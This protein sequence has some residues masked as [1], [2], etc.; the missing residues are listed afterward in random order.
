MKW[1][2]QKRD[3]A[4]LEREVIKYLSSKG[5]GGGVTATEIAFGLDEDID[6]IAPILMKLLL[7]RN[8]WFETWGGRLSGHCLVRWH[9][10]TNNPYHF[11][12]G[13]DYKVASQNL[14]NTNY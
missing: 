5:K 6:V 11:P 3:D 12:L 1:L 9:Y 13:M 4:T 2:F 14:K 10:G 8:A 7:N